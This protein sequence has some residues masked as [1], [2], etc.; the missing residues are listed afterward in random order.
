LH[1]LATSTIFGMFDALPDRLEIALFLSQDSWM[2]GDREGDTQV[3]TLHGDDLL[4]IAVFQRLF[5]LGTHGSRNGMAGADVFQ[6]LFQ[7][8]N[9]TLPAEQAH[10]W[11][12]EPQD[13]DAAPTPVPA[14][15]AVPAASEQPE[16]S[17]Q[18]MASPAPLADAH[19]HLRDDVLATMLGFAGLHLQNG[20]RIRCRTLL[21]V[22]SRKW[23]AAMRR[24]SV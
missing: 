14:S 17:P 6:N 13:G 2:R 10:S 9:L 12:L 22:A 21:R 16:V 11:S 7:L 20:R 19:G 4:D 15:D 1:D 5:A 8:G 24:R 3:A 18:P 23:R